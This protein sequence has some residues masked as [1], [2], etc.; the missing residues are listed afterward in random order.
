MVRTLLRAD[1]RLASIRRFMETSSRMD[2]AS[3]VSTSTRRC[4][5]A[6]AARSRAQTRNSADASSTSWANDRNPESNGM[7]FE[8]LVAKASTCG[9]MSRGADEA[10]TTMACAKPADA[11]KESRINSVHAATASALLAVAPGC[12]LRRP[13]GNV[14]AAR[15]P[16]NPATS[17]RVTRTQSS[18]TQM[19]TAARRSEAM[20]VV[21]VPRRPEESGVPVIPDDTS[22]VDHG[23]RTPTI[24]T[25]PMPA[26]K[27]SNATT[28]VI[29][30]LRPPPFAR[31]AQIPD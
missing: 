19:G 7:P 30:T 1:A 12:A 25:I 29:T 11:A 3:A 28:G 22:W 23:M 5:L 18:P 27:P 15:P 9:R 26:P 14:A 31:P 6:V 16:S 13:L 17:H 24:P 8:S 10:V 2:S 21:R 20:R 4:D